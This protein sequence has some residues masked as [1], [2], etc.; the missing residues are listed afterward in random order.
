M[1]RTHI[2]TAMLTAA[3]TIGLA[4]AFG[5]GQPD[6][7]DP[8]AG[9]VGDTQ[10]SLTSIDAKVDALV[11]DVNDITTN[12]TGTN[13]QVVYLEA[14]TPHQLNAVQITS[15]PTRVIAVSGWLSHAVL[16]DGPGSF[17]GGTSPIT[18]GNVIGRIGFDIN[19]VIGSG[20]GQS[21]VHR[22]S[23]NSDIGVVAQNGLYASY[24]VSG[25]IA[26]YYEELSK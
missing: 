2:L 17:P 11:Q 6:G 3:G 8:P 14:G 9:P 18:S 15:G 22:G 21:F 13:V 5:L 26:I 4:A 23:L 7:I 1:Q 20:A 19:Q 25:W 10:P 12:T 24:Q 16:F